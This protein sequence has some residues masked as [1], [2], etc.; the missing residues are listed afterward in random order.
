MIGCIAY[1]NFSHLKTFK[2]ELFRQI[3]K[4]DF[5]DID[6]KFMKCTYDLALMF[7]IAEMS[8]GKF[9]FIED[10]LYV[11]NNDNPININKII[12]EEQARICK[13]IRNRNVYKSL[14]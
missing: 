14:Y 4:E 12:I 6:G 5:L 9:K 10:I 13:L 1:W 3:K 7:P 11:Y 8:G 2:F